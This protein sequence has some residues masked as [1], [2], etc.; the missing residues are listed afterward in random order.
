MHV[1]FQNWCR[2]CVRAKGRETPHHESSPGGVSKFATDSGHGE[3]G[4]PITILAWYDT[5]T[6]A[7]FANVVRCKDTSHGCAESAFAHNEA[8]ES[9]TAERPKTAHYRRQT[10]TKKAQSETVTPTAALSE[11][12]KPSKGRSVLSRL[13][14]TTDRCDDWS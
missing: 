2:H 1:P 8:S 13:H 7:F 14:R 11:Q 12:T 9:D 3:D 4:T 5:L 6:K 10:C